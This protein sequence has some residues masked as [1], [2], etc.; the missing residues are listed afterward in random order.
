MQAQGAAIAGDMLAARAAAEEGRDLADAI[1]DRFTSRV[2]Y[3]WGLHW[4]QIIEGDLADAV[5]QL[6]ELVSEAEATHDVLCRVLGLTSQAHALAYNGAP[7]AA[8]AAADAAIEGAAEVGGLYAGIG[9]GGLAVAALAS[10]DVAAADEAIAAGWQQISLHRGVAAVN[11]HFVAQV[12]LARGDLIE[13]RRWAD[14][15]VSTTAGWHRSHALKTRARVARAQG[16]PEQAERDLN[17]ALACVADAGAFLGVPGILEC[18]A[19]LAGEAGR[20]SEAARLLGTADA[21]RQRT[22]EVRFQVNQAGYDTSVVML[23]NVLG[24]KDFDAEWADGLAVST[25]EA[26]AYAQ[27]G[28]GERTLPASG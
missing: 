17:D 15:A 16:K 9:Y 3:L 10:G 22:G 23:R 4:P 19:Q 21:I 24:D 2:C 12:A 27:R 8:R 13:A 28:R 5:A 25:D 1:G 11:T 6:S 26:I 20:H 14:Q 18:L 7:S